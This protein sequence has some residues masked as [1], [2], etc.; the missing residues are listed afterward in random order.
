ML[1]RLSLKKRWDI[2]LTYYSLERISNYAFQQVERAEE[3][4]TEIDYKQ[5]LVRK[6]W[7]RFLSDY[8][9]VLKWEMSHRTND[10]AASN[11]SEQWFCLSWHTLHFKWYNNKSYNLINRYG[12]SSFLFPGMIYFNFCA[13]FYTEY[14][15]GSNRNIFS[16]NC[17]MLQSDIS[18]ITQ[19]MFATQKSLMLQ[20]LE[21]NVMQKYLTKMFCLC[22]EIVLKRTFNRF[23][24][25]F[26]RF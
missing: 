22:W 4:K 16:L 19:T 3:K 12:K 26:D 15:I 21:E 5:R 11:S 24:K 8:L 18:R 23:P 17:L 14:N 25:P 13:G 10:L 9:M 2:F 1:M 6:T 7:H 20:V